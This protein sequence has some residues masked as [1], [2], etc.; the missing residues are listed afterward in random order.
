MAY[1]IPKNLKYQEKILFN[2]SIWQSLWVGLFGFLVFTVVFKTPLIFELKI[3][4][5]IFL[6]LLGIGFA[7][8]DLKNHLAVLAG[9]L[10]KPRQLGYLDR[11]VNNF[12]EVKKIESNAVFLKDN[13]SIAIFIE[14]KTNGAHA[15][16]GGNTRLAATRRLTSARNGL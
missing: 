7:F 3:V 4:L 13:S 5:S 12:L 6:A 9:F 14:E 8:F 16:A 15:P 10:L 1:E 11:R 2:L